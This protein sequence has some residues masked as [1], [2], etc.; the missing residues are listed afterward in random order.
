MYRFPLAKPEL[1]AKWMAAMRRDKWTP[2]ATDVICSEHF[3][4][5]CLRVYCNT[6]HLKE[7]A[8]PTLFSF[9]AHLQKPVCR[10]RVL[11]R[12]SAAAVS[13]A[14]SADADTP[15][16]ST[17]SV[18]AAAAVPVTM[19]H[20]YATL[21]SP[22]GVKRKYEQIAQRE[23]RRRVAVSAKLKNVR[24][25]LVRCR[26][27][28]HTMRDV[29]TELKRR[30]DITAEAVALLERCFGDIPAEMLKRKLK[31][32][33]TDVYSANIKAFALT[34]HFYSPKA[35]NFVRQ[36]FVNALP[37]VSTLRRWSSAVNG[38]PGFTEVSFEV[39]YHLFTLLLLSVCHD[40]IV[41]LF[42]VCP[43]PS[44]NVVCHIICIVFFYVWGSSC[45]SVHWSRTFLTLF[46]KLLN[47]FLPTY[48]MAAA[49]SGQQLMCS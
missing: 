43:W 23:K 34:L 31:G 46:W 42:S 28:L 32:H 40:V 36:S 41:T 33:T 19:H 22:R 4:R 18:S 16:T 12:P 2:K 45:L 38:K 9:P 1:L 5:Q 44:T 20:S 30:R 15:S 47:T 7:D 39:K 17:G 6:V 11:S 25:Q 27:R 29:I 14:Q 35:Y 3:D 8:V 48:T 24:R 21:A 49:H 37:H 13:P 10:R 26:A